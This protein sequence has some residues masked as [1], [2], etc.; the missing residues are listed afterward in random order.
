MTHGTLGIGGGAAPRVTRPRPAP[1]RWRLQNLPH[2]L[3]GSW[4]VLVARLLGIPTYYGVVEALVR[5]ADGTATRY[6]VVSRRVVTDA[7]VAFL[8]DC[9]ETSDPL[10]DDFDYHG[11][12]TGTTAEA[13]GDTALETASGSRVSGTPSQPAANQYR[14]V[15]TFAIT[16]TVAITEHGLFNASSGGTLMDRSVFAA[17]NL[18]DGDSLEMSY[19]LTLSAGG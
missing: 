15:G 13:A 3:R 9:L 11:I 8:V 5:H 2:W 19:T 7:F 4:R 10:I 12:G 16:S 18:Q 14:S 17:L 6:G 1:L